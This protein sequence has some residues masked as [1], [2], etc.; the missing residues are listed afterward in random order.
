MRYILAN[1]KTKRP[2]MYGDNIEDILSKYRYVI[3]TNGRPYSIFNK[4]TYIGASNEG[5]INFLNG[6]GYYSY[7]GYLIID[8]YNSD[9]F[10]FITYT[11]DE[12]DMRFSELLELIKINIR[13]V[14]IDNILD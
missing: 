4:N 9:R 12:Q 10:D 7:K 11:G 5:I 13:K 3:E 8:T 2:I 6:G 14:N 1:I